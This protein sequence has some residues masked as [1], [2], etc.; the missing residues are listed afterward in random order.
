M[1]LTRTTYLESFFVRG[2]GKGGVQGAHAEYLEVIKDGDTEIARKVLP[3]QPIALV[4]AALAPILSDVVAAALVAHAEQLTEIATLTAAKAEA[5]AARDTALADVTAA[6]AKIAT[7]TERLAALQ[8]PTDVNGVPQVV[9]MVQAQLALL[10][11]GLLDKVDAVI[12]SIP[13]DQGRAAQIEW[14]KAANVHRDHALIA[15]LQGALGLTGEQIDALFVA[16]SK[17]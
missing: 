3:A 12:A 16:A 10:G 17:L 6:N 2:D 8:P 11:A 4:P 15:A 1:A 5:D 14:S 13:G 9:T 7:L